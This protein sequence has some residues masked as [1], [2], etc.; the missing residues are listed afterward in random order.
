MKLAQLGERKIIKIFEKNFKGKCRNVLAGIGEDACVLELNGSLLVASTDLIT[1]HAHMPREMT[2]RQIGKFVVNANLSDIAAM[3]AKPLGLIFSF[4]LP[5]NLDE[6]FVKE[7]ARG[8]DAA[9][10]EH[11]T[12]V[13]G[14]D[15]KEHQEIT[16]A[17]TAFGKVKKSNLLLRSNAKAGELICVT[18]KI[19]SAAAGFYCL[20]K[21]LK[22]NEKISK[23]FIKAALEPRARVREGMILSE[24]ASACMDV[25]DGLAY[26]LHEIARASAKGFVVYENNIPVEPE[27]NTI[28]RLANITTREIVFHKGGDY[29][30]L[31]TISPEKFQL[32]KKKMKKLAPVTV[33]GEVTKHETLIT[34]ADGRTE[35]L[36][37]R[38]Y[39]SFVK[40][41]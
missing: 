30:L 6:A 40:Q 9:C 32:L 36:S 26:S 8:I 15:T 11:A 22:V 16:I 29:E 19:G 21:N 38:G 39:E 20:T 5:R 4:G 2:P 17:G 33:I 28:S 23:K 37:P 27:I 41:F 31:F 14:G 13:L 24:Y 35:I 34:L 1:Q 18:G 12:C 10:R 7:L 3:G 25:T